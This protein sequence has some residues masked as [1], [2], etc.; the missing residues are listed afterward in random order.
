MRPLQ[1]LINNYSAQKSQLEY[2]IEAEINAQYPSVDKL[3]KLIEKLADINTKNGYL[4]KLLIDIANAN[5]RNVSDKSD[6]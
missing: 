4:N 3:D 2:E 5:T 1:I 6:K